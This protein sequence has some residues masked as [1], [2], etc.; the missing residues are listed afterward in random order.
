MEVVEWVNL[1]QWND[2]RRGNGQE[3][4]DIVLGLLMLLAIAATQ[5]RWRPG[6]AAAAERQR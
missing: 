4:L 1:Y 2:V 6:M 3:Q 5:R